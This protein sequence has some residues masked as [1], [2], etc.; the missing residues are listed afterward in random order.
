MHTIC[1]VEAEGDDEY[2]GKVCFD[3]HTPPA[4]AATTT[5]TTTK[6][7]ITYNYNFRILQ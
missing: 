6:G 3:W 5:T 4:A 2:K 1:G 7:C